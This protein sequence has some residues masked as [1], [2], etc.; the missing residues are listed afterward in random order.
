MLWWFNFKNVSHPILPTC[1]HY[2]LLAY[3]PGKITLP[4]T[5]D[6]VAFRQRREAAC[7]DVVTGGSRIGRAV[8]IYVC[9]GFIQIHN[10]H[11][12]AINLDLS[13]Q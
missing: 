7:A 3:S 10:A 13:M 9:M 8:G 12:R 2:G 5:V 1:S 6:D 11:N 4:G